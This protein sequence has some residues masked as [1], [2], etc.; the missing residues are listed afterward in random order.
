MQAIRHALHSGTCRRSTA[1]HRSPLNHACVLM[2][3][4]LPQPPSSG[5]FCSPPPFMGS[6]RLAPSRFLGSGTS[7]PLMSVR[8]AS[9]TSSLNSKGWVSSRWYAALVSFE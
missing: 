5:C 9:D 4:A 7:K 8:A 6:L 1:S 3:N 2:G